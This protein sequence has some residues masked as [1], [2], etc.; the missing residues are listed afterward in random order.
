VS[1]LDKRIKKTLAAAREAA[2]DVLAAGGFAA[3]TMEAVAE[4]SHISKSTLYRHW[5]DRMALLSDALETLNRQPRPIELLEPGDLRERVIE[6]LTHLAEVLDKARISSVLPALIE[7]AEYYPQVADF[8]HGY[9]ARRRE[10]LVGLLQKGVEIG[11][12]A[13]DFDPE[14]AALV[15]SGPLFYRRLMSPEPFRTGVVAALVDFC[16][17]GNGRSASCLK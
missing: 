7:A 8:L 14:L 9:S 2:L 16:V 3:F 15:L 6:L 12:L 5:P 17:S 13:P 10:T 11:E 4:H 1:E